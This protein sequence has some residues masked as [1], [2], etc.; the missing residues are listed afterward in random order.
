MDKMI[1]DF[2][3]KPL[4]GKAFVNVWDLLM[5]ARDRLYFNLGLVHCWEHRCTIGVCWG[6]CRHS[7]ANYK[8]RGASGWK[9]EAGIVIFRILAAVDRFSWIFWK[10]ESC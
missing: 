7:S 9:Y 10:A 3:T 1:A 8:A 6:R 5:G 4:Q 2:L